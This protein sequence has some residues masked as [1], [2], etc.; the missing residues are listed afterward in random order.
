MYGVYILFLA[1]DS[2]RLPFPSLTGGISPSVGS[3]LA[4][5][6]MTTTLYLIEQS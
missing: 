5:N 1:H 2:S 3:E 6:Q 4:G